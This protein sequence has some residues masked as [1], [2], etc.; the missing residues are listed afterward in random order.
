VIFSRKR[1]KAGPNSEAAGRGGRYKR[2]TD[3]IADN[4][5]ELTDDERVADLPAGPEFGPYDVSHAPKDSVS[6][7]DL[8][9]LRIPTV[10]GV[11]IQLEAAPS[12]EIQRVQLAYGGSRLQLGAFA[13]P[14]TEGIWDEIRAELRAALVGGGAKLAEVDGE[15]GREL[16][17]RM[18]GG[19]GTVEVRHIGI[20]GP[21]W[22]VHGVYV[23]AAAVD[24]DQA[25]PLR[26]ALRGLVVDR[27]TEA[28]PVKEPLPLRLP[29]EAAAQLAEMVA[30]DQ[31]TAESAE[32][33]PDAATSASSGTASAPDSES[34]AQSSG[35]ASPR[36][37]GTSSRGGAATRRGQRR[38]R[39][40]NEGS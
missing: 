25:G 7:L 5:D 34:A 13:A 18:G 14:R 19:Q 36:R 4:G 6:R 37:N 2:E 17:A 31:K 32:Q 40:V 38:G 39:A 12:G 15:Y 11:D 33:E 27:G 30:N 16:Q 1:G 23:G 21:R 22:F 29:A 28:R 10:A 35:T 26:D 24:P 3:D 9:A 8:G 20:D